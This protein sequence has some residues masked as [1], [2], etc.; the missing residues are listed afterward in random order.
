MENNKK[1]IAEIKKLEI[2]SVKQFSESSHLNIIKDKAPEEI[3]N[4]MYSALN[5]LTLLPYEEIRRELIVVKR[6]GKAFS[7]FETHF[8]GFL[9]NIKMRARVH[10]RLN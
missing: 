8:L 10:M 3:E 6:I 7:E 4:L 5:D 1:Y 2:K 9:K